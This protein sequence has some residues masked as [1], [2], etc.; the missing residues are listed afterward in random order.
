MCGRRHKK[1][2]YFNMLF[3]VYG[4][5]FAFTLSLIVDNNLVFSHSL[6]LATGD[7]HLIP[8]Y[9]ILSGKQN[10]ATL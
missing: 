8:G 2:H 10:F 3:V 9:K 7:F 4:D 1:C 6:H 5:D